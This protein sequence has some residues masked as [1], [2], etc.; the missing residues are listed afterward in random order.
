RAAGEDDLLA[1]A[2]VEEPCGAFASGFVGISGAIAQFVNAPVDVGVVAFV[3]T[4]DGVKDGP[5]LLRRGGVV[6]VN[7]G[8]AVDFLIEDRE[9]GSEIRPI[10]RGRPDGDWAGGS[11]HQKRRRLSSRLRI[12]FTP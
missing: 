6:E 8:V 10:R 7:E 9:V 3:I 5:G 12:R 2:S 11:V 1:S 4:E